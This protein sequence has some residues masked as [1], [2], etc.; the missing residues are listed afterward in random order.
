MPS[1]SY[2]AV[3]AQGQPT[4][5]VITAPARHAAIDAVMARGLHPVKLQ[6]NDHAAASPS[7]WAGLSRQRVSAA[8]AEAF[9][10]EAS[11]L[12][13]AGVSLSRALQI[14]SQEASSPA[15][16]KQWGEIRDAVTGG[17][18]LADAMAQ[19]RG[20]FSPIHIAMIRA[21]EEGGFLPV[22]LSQIAELRGRE[23]DL[24]GRVTGAM[25]YPAV[26]ALLMIGVVIFL[27][28]FFIPRFS[29]IFAEF[30]SSLPL[31]T[32]VIVAASGIVGTYGPFVAAALVV[33]GVLIQRAIA[34]PAGR[35]RFERIMLATPLVGVI[36]ARFALVRFARMLGTLIGAG[37]PLVKSLRTARDA[38]GN[39]TLH[40]AVDAAIDQVQAGEPLARS[41]G[42][43]GRLFPASVVEM[44]AIAE[45]TGRLDHEL[46]RLAEVYET[47][48]DRRLRTTVALLEP[49]L[50]MIMAGV[51]GTI[52]VGM[53]LPVFTL[54][55]L[56]K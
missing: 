13:T 19:C 33:A 37:V 8:A 23:R 26:L 42:A 52:V 38:L 44:I 27:L 30:G 15:A 36:S 39:Q 35:S 10:R 3:D 17:S 48:L 18:S 5:G 29:G 6:E 11:N 40:A 32:R 7:L 21:G 41:L 45:E 51:V 22:V 43:C 4:S 49:L 20:T 46:I 55:D 28:T 9:T 31:L 24:V 50:L 53:L 47:D 54:Q 34:S 56:I 12:L 25:I 14:L 1:F 2:T 16:R